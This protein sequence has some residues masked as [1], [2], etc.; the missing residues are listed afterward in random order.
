MKFEL[1][2]ES[3]VCHPKYDHWWYNVIDEDICSNNAKI[4]GKLKSGHPRYGKSTLI[5]RIAPDI[6]RRIDVVVPGNLEN[7]NMKSLQVI[8][9]LKKQ[10]IKN[11]LQ[12]ELHEQSKKHVFKVSILKLPEWWRKI[13]LF[14]LQVGQEGHNS[15]KLCSKWKRSKWH[16]S[17]GNNSTFRVFITWKGF[18]NMLAK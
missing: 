14:N 1:L 3:L 13:S 7:Y 8:N 12:R 18:S 6:T 10:F 17:A 2:A 4:V 9:C 5:S 15:S 16:C 11:I